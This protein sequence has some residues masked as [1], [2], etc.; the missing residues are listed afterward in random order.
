MANNRM[1]LGPKAAAVHYER[2]MVRDLLYK[3]GTGE[4]KIDSTQ[5]AMAC[6]IAAYDGDEKAIL[7]QHIAALIDG[8]S[9]K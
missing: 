1:D 7:L 9:E 2:R 6:I 4:I 8:I 3:I 5:N